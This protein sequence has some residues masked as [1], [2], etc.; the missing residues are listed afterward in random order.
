[1]HGSVV[2]LGLWLMTRSSYERSTFQ[3]L[4]AIVGLRS[5]QLVIAIATSRR[6]QPFCI[7]PAP[8]I[9]HTQLVRFCRLIRYIVGAQKSTR[10]LKRK[11]KGK[12]GTTRGEI[13]HI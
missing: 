4:L 8:L 13:V 10:M 7:Q 1:M 9:A 3:E 2:Y 12:E 6:T 5:Y 11:E